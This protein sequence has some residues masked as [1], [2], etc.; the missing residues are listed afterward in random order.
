MHSYIDKEPVDLTGITAITAL[1]DADSIAYIIGHGFADSENA[2]EVG[3]AVDQMV[4]DMLVQ[5]QARQYAGFLSPKK[6]FRH[7]VDAEYKAK[8][9][10]PSE[11]I[12]KW[13]PFID[14][15]LRQSWGFGEWND[16][17]ADDA[18]AV[19]QWNMEN[20]VICSP[21]KDLKQVPGNHY[22]YK[23][24]LKFLITPDE[25]NYNL[26][27]QLLMGDA[28]DGIKGCPGVGK[29]GAKQ[30][31][32]EARRTDMPLM[33]AVDKTY[34]HKCPGDWHKHLGMT[35][36]LVSMR[37]TMNAMEAILLLSKLHSFDLDAAGTS[38]YLTQSERMNEADDIFGDW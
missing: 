4:S 3:Q 20:S 27:Y 14:E 24:G 36:E 38:S 25:A 29:V 5:V 35:I 8:R 37:R 26:C 28:G 12:K 22:D 16:H 1:I 34:M 11:G 33:V 31:L 23:K 6:T 18:V 30:I 10:E 15:Y 9:S 2:D 13:K 17:E 7:R 19:M 21:D 32:D